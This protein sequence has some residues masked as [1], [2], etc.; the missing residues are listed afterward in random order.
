MCAPITLERHALLR[1]VDA[2]DLAM[3]MDP[4]TALRGDPKIGCC[5]R[6]RVGAVVAE[7]D[8]RMAPPD[9]V[10]PL[11]LGGSDEFDLE[12]GPA[13]CVGL[14]RQLRRIEAVAVEIERGARCSTDLES[15]PLGARAKG[16]DGQVG[17]PPDAHRPPP[18]DALRHLRE[19]RV[20]F[21]LE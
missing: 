13:P 1:R 10:A 7:A 19:R 4:C 6:A 8:D 11:G 20:E 3:R 16:L 18:A 17:A 14:G 15:E 5:H 2:H 21:I 9:P 12:S